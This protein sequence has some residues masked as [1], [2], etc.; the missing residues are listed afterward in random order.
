MCLNRI[1]N[2]DATLNI[3][4]FAE[5]VQD[6]NVPFMNGILEFMQVLYTDINLFES[7]KVEQMLV[8]NMICVDPEE[9][10][11]GLALKMIKWSQ[12]LAE[13]KGIKALTA[14]TTGIA[15]SKVF[16]KVAFINHVDIN[17]R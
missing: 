1:D 13:N 8:L 6:R 16:Q 3:P 14:E 9:S 17:V 4:S 12:N 15:S 7:F 11:K 10:G 2:K 5:A